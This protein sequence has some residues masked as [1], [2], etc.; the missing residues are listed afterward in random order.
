MTNNLIVLIGHRAR[1][2]KDY[3]AEHLKEIVDNE[4]PH[5]K[6]TILHWADP[7]K[8]E[9]AFDPKWP[10]ISIEED[11]SMLLR[12]PSGTGLFNNTYN[13]VSREEVPA[14][15]EYMEDRGLTTHDGMI[16]KDSPLLQAWGTGYRRKTCP[17]YW[18][19]KTNKIIKSI[20]ASDKTKSHII[21]IPDSRF[22]NELN[23]AFANLRTDKIYIDITRL[24]ADGTRF[25]DPSRDKDHQS[26]KELD[27]IYCDG[28]ISRFITATSVDTKHLVD[29]GL[30]IIQRF[31]LSE[32]PPIEHKDFYSNKEF[33]E[34]EEK[35]ALN[36]LAVNPIRG[37]Y[38]EQD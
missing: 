3:L 11:G 23:G 20:I 32:Q 33:Y 7:L 25:Y 26:E 17:D 9:V 24:N 30:S 29:T 21:F 4:Y 12:E 37:L 14:L 22:Y 1:S 36:F 10:L 28:Y 15:Y 34:Y 38:D 18:V 5:I 16:E 19:N 13:H 35:E 8:N 2:G 6:A 31:L 27:D